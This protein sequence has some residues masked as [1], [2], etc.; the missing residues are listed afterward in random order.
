MVTALA[1]YPGGSS[2]ATSSG[3]VKV[4]QY[5]RIQLDY[6]PK[7]GVDNPQTYTITVS[8]RGNGE[9][10]FE[11]SIPF[12]EAMAKAGL[13]ID[14]DQITTDTIAQDVNDSI[15]MTVS[16]GSSAPSGKKQIYVRA[17]STASTANGNDSIYKDLVMLIDVQP[18][19][20]QAGYSIG[21]VALVIMII[22]VVVIFFA[23]KKGKLRFK[24]KPKPAPVKVETKEQKEK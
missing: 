13:S 6:S 16:Y 3:T 4:K 9:D 5:F 12:Q 2:I 22:V 23:K 14:F 17:T 18:W 21:A 11:F 1:T 19:H 7:V 10:S 24:R 8:N 20:G 15:R